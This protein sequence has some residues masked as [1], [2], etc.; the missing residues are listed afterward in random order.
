MS[1]DSD[2][3]IANKIMD[4]KRAL[5]RTGDF[6]GADYDNAK[7]L[8]EAACEMADAPEWARTFYWMGP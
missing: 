2:R 4:I 7:R 5:L 3:L 6:D 8:H 1:T